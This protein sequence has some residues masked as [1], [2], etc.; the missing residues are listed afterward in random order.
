MM[1]QLG[2]T[3]KIM[4][5]LSFYTA[6]IFCSNFIN[7]FMIGTLMGVNVNLFFLSLVVQV[8][9]F[10]IYG[11]VLNL[12]NRIH[13]FLGIDSIIKLISV[14]LLTYLSENFLFLFIRQLISLRYL[15]FTNFLSSILILLANFMYVLFIKN[16][17]SIFGK[18]IFEANDL[19]IK[20]EKYL[21]IGAGVAG[22][23]LFKIF[24][25]SLK[26][27]VEVVGFLDDDP[28]K[29]DIYILN[30]KVLGII[31]EFPLFFEQYKCDKVVL[32]IPSL[33]YQRK[34][35]ITQLAMES[36]IKIET[37]PSLEDIATGKLSISS[38]KKVDIVDLL[39]RDEVN[40]D[41]GMIKDQLQGKTLLITGAGGS[42]G[43]EIVRQLIQFKP[44]KMILLGHG[45]YSIYKIYSEI[46]RKVANLGI[47]IISIIADIKDEQRIEQIM[48]EYQPEIVYH[49]AAYKH[50][51]LMEI[52]SI[53]A[54]KNNI[55]G[56]LTM[57]KVSKRHH[58]K[59][60]VMISTDKAVNPT[61]VM[62][63]T[64]RIAEMCLLSLN[65]AGRTKFSMVR[66]GNVLGSRGS[67]IPLFEQ[68]IAEGGPVTVT[69]FR[70]TRYFMTIPEASCLVIQSGILA[71]GGDIFLLDMGEAVKIKDLATMMINLSGKTLEEISV[72]ETGIRPGEKLY[73]ELFLPSEKS[74]KKI[75][76]KIFVS[77][78]QEFDFGKIQ[79]FLDDLPS[80]EEEL[81]RRLIEYAN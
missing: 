69:D 42:I 35:E 58:I 24:S 81:K 49:A 77:T 30:K 3:Y 28:N 67:V 71:E 34:Q 10:L 5:I 79:K 8:M 64:K 38:L 22:F 65:E 36:N 19:A 61:N 45:E 54:V 2:K 16:E 32:A 1:F 13:H 60:F 18:Q 74:F 31:K 76:D 78:F 63:A 26:N 41:V 50:V 29:K 51:P 27:K 9:L 33:S 43:S 21:I 62:G 48:N 4:I 72:V 25:N 6:I 46:E 55:Y 68:Q 7:Y 47:E 75:Y 80:E 37:M 12:F 57:A 11:K 39:R 14:G 66:F 15:F 20:R 40:L 52:N 23:Q 59:S 70:M 53:E 44:K 56:T 73:E 17:R